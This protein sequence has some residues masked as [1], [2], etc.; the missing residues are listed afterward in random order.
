M[1]NKEAEVLSGLWNDSVVDK[2]VVG[3]RN[4]SIWAPKN[5][6]FPQKKNLRDYA[7]LFPEIFCS[8]AKS[9]IGATTAHLHHSHSNARS[10]TYT[11]AHATLDPQRTEQ[12]QGSNPQPHGS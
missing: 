11:T 12:G 7:Y 10:A 9:L 3:L 4:Q 6:L 1:K 5:K 8:K 2:E